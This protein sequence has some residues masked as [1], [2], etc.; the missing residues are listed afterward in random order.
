M[1]QGLRSRDR[2]KLRRSQILLASAQGQTP[3]Q[4]A[5][6]VGCTAQTVRNVIRAFEDQGLGCLVAQSSR[7]KTGNVLGL[8]FS[9]RRTG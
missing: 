8:L 5:R 3:S 9:L 7:P 2:F 4:I 1:E 6:H